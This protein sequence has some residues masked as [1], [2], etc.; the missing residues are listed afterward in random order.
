MKFHES[1]PDVNEQLGEFNRRFQFAPS[2]HLFE[3]LS[4]SNSFG[5]HRD[6]QSEFVFSERFKVPD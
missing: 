3:M 1:I 2:F 5:T 4:P 6:I